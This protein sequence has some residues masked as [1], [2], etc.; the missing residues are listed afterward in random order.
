MKNSLLQREINENIYVP[1]MRGPYENQIALVAPPL[2]CHHQVAHCGRGKQTVYQQLHL[3]TKHYLDLLL[4][5]HHEF[6]Q[7]LSPI[8]KHGLQGRNG[9]SILPNKVLLEPV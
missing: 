9:D 5:G 8:P 6:L 3:P 1:I 2:H 4:Q 7:L